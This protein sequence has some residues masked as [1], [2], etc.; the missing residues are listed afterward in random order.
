MSSK[1][2]VGL[3]AVAVLCFCIGCSSS[4][5]E[6]KSDE[7]T[8]AE[9]VVIHNGEL[10]ALDRL[11]RKRKELVTEY[12]A[13]HRPEGEVTLKSVADLISSAGAASKEGSAAPST[14]PNVALDQ[15]VEN[16]EKA[17][18]AT[19]KLIETMAQAGGEGEGQVVYSEEFQKQLADLDAEIAAQQARVDRARQARDAAE[20]K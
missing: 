18:Q 14:D 5:E 9:L 7:P 13:K 6:P 15:A 11:E 12:E 17:Q 8:Y 3:W 16:A 1:N 4:K 2:R 20:Q 10:Q 19:S